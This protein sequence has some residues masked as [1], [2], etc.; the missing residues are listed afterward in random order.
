HG[1]LEAFTQLP[2]QRGKEKERQN[3]Q[4]SAEIDQQALVGGRTELEQN[5]QDQGLL[6]HV[7]V[8][9]TQQL[10]TEERQKPA[11]AKQTELRAWRLGT[12]GRRR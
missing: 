11:F 5:R 4:Q 9:C 2:A 12:S 1:L 8:E 10:G 3:E 7:V 6:E